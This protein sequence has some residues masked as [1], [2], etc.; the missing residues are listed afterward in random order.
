MKKLLLVLI[1][2]LLVTTVNAQNSPRQQRK[3]KR[4][5]QAVSYDSLLTAAIKNS[6]FTFTAEYMSQDFGQKYPISGPYTTLWVMPEQFSVLL[7]YFTDSQPSMVAPQSI[8]FSVQNFKY[9]YKEVGGMYYVKIIAP[10]AVNNQSNNKMQN[11]RYI[12]NLEISPV[13]GNAFLTVTPN[14]NASISFTGIIS[15]ND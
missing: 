11:G 1:I 6:S 2:A 10:N 5:A 14:Y 9:S 13:T 7:P 15:P 4:A 3:A 12:F 8:D